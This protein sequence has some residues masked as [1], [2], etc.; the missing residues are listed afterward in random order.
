MRYEYT[1]AV[2]SVLALGHDVLAVLAIYLAMGRTISLTVVAAILTVIGYSINDKVVEFDRIRENNANIKGMAFSDIVN[3]SINQTLSRTLITSV[4]TFIVVF[5]L[6]IG[7]GVA[8]NDFVF[9]MMLGVII[10]TYSSIF[11]AAPFVAKWNEHRINKA[12]KK[13]K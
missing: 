9:I 13:A 5:I 10:G 1:Y 4:T 2:S 11:L 3:L 6:Y 8:I 7:G 12:A